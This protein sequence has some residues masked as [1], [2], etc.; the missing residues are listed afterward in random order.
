VKRDNITAFLDESLII[1]H[2]SLYPGVVGTNYVLFI[3]EIKRSFWN[4]FIKPKVVKLLPLHPL[5]LHMIDES[6]GN[7]ALGDDIIS[8]ILRASTP[9]TIA[10]RKSNNKGIG[11][12]AYS[13]DYYGA[14]ILD[15]EDRWLTLRRRDYRN[16]KHY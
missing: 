5:R 16:H 3:P 10:W 11:I 7:S 6:V 9:K 2:Y 4:E 14:N 15:R 8:V 13:E 1:P 12:D